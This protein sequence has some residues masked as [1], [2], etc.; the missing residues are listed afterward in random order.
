[1]KPKSHQAARRAQSEPSDP[2]LPLR[3]YV[4]RSL[5]G[6]LPVGFIAACLAFGTWTSSVEP[7]DDSPADPATTAAKNEPARQA[8]PV[9]VAPSAEPGRTIL[10][11]DMVFGR[12]SLARDLADW[13]SPPAL[14]HL[15][16][17]SK[18]L[19]TRTGIQLG[20]LIVPNLGGLDI[21]GFALKAARKWALGQKKK[22]NGILLLVARHEHK[23][24]IEVGRGLEGELTDLESHRI[25]DEVMLPLLARGEVDNA[26][27]AGVEG[28]IGIVA[29]DL[30][31]EH[32]DWTPSAPAPIEPAPS[33]RR[34]QTVNESYP[35]RGL[36]LL[37]FA[38]MVALTGWKV[39]V[40]LKYRWLLVPVAAIGIAFAIS[41]AFGALLAFFSFLGL[42]TLAG[43]LRGSSTDSASS[44]TNWSSS[45]SP[46][47]GDDSSSSGSSGG[48]GSFGGGG[49]SGQW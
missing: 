3:T 45:S 39:V 48:G 8:D 31:I 7:T 26:L 13:A 14:E 24:R 23:V 46:S 21:E 49:A 16:S 19:E 5:L 2:I 18:V 10:P 34:E 35:G 44:S 4:K 6:I 32:R 38:V 11:E 37:L 28:I 36:Y 25:I 30:T 22:D 29:P 40:R 12:G 33:V 17:L 41:T 9:P 42:G 27:T 47:R 20:V 43:L 1:M 15:D